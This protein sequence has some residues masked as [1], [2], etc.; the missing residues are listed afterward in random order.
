MLDFFTSVLIFTVPILFPILFMYYNDIL[1]KPNGPEYAALKE[2]LSN[3]G[4]MISHYRLRLRSALARADRFFEGTPDISPT[5][6]HEWSIRAFDT[7][8]LFA[9]FYP[10]AAAAIGWLIFAD[11]GTFGE[12]LGFVAHEHSAL[13]R[14]I[15]SI[16]VIIGLSLCFTGSVWK[17]L[18]GMSIIILAS[19]LSGQIGVSTPTLFAVISVGIG[20]SV[21][22]S[23][24]TDFMLN[25]ATLLGLVLIPIMIAFFGTS[26]S[27]SNMILRGFLFALLCS[28]VYFSEEKAPKTRSTLFLTIIIAIIIVWLALYFNT[29]AREPHFVLTASIALI[30]IPLINAPFDW[31]SIGLTRFC[32]RKSL[33][34]KSIQART[35]WAAL[36]ITI[37]LA[38]MVLLCVVMIFALEGFNATAA[39]YGVDFTPAPIREQV[40]QIRNAS[41]FEGRHFWLY[42]AL[43][44]TLA[45]T[46]FHMLIWLTSLISAVWG[47]NKYLYARIEPEKLIL[48]NQRMWT[49]SW[50][51]A[52][53]VG[54]LV[55]GAVIC[56]LL[57]EGLTRTPSIS[58]GFLWVIDGTYYAARTV[59]GTL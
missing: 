46:L 36:D 32:L 51:S 50:L 37:A 13:Q 45:P 44:T 9:L 19:Y 35:A 23:K 30:I 2:R 20:L 27:S 29:L 24:D 18:L 47:Q 55:L 5:G 58:Q 12:A 42:F 34:A 17:A 4:T 59:F 28:I 22:Y 31:A 54:G 41:G 7:C 15:L 8:L 56:T 43:F 25:A 40:T 14:I 16:S 52:Q 1:K 38:C 21:Y 57:W 6:G 49:A 33:I 10:I 3:D 11:A 53:W 26:L 48:S 39:A